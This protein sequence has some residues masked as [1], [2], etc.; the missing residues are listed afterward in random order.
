MEIGIDEYDMIKLGGD[1]N[2]SGGTPLEKL[3]RNHVYQLLCRFLAKTSTL[4]TDLTVC[5]WIALESQVEEIKADIHITNCF[6]VPPGGRVHIPTDG[7]YKAWAQMDEFER[8][9]IPDGEITVEV[10]WQD[11]MGVMTEHSVKV[12][13]ADKRDKAYI[14]VET[15]NQSGN[16]VIAMKV[17]GEIF[18]VGIFGVRTI[19]RT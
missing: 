8:M 6:I 3:E 2:N 5:P 14:V 19:I 12:M 1:T 13:N 9:P 10:L 7:V 17:N 16:A 11:E 4:D 15:G 18:G